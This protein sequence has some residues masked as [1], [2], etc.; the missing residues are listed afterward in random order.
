MEMPVA[1]K[2]PSPPATKRPLAKL[3]DDTAA[4]Y[5][6][7]QAAV[8]VELFTI[9]LY[10]STMYSIQGTHQINS[11]WLSY[12]KGRQ[13]P[14]MG[15]GVRAG[16]GTDAPNQKA[17]NIIFSV[18]IQE[19]LHLQ[20][21]ANLAT[22]IGASPCFTGNALQDD[23]HGWTCYGPTKT[24]IPHI[25]DLQH[26]ENYKH[27]RVALEELNANQCDL[28]LAI[29]QPEDQF[30][31]ELAAFHAAHPQTYFPQ[32]PFENWTPGMTS[33]DLPLF[34]TIGHMYQCYA[35][36]ISIEYE[37][38]ET[39]WDKLYKPG[40]VQQDM[41]NSTVP[42][43]AKAEFPHFATLFAKDDPNTI[44]TFDKAIDMMA[45][46]TDQGEGNESAI[47]RYRRG[48]M[49]K[50]VQPDYREDRA[51]LEADYPSYTNAGGHARSA[52]AAARADY[53][54]YDHY[55]RF[56]QVKDMLAD[57]TTW[58]HWHADPASTWTDAMLTNS[59]YDAAAA[60]DNIPTPAQVATALNNLKQ[61][62][63]TLAM[64]STVA[65]GAVYGITSVLDQYWKDQDL[66]FPYPS[67]VGAGDRFSICWAVLGKSP[68]LSVG[69]P[70]PDQSTLYHACQGLSL[71]GD[72][73]GSNG[74][75]CAA[76]AVYHTCRGSN[77]CHAQGGC[78]FAQLDTGGGSCG[79]AVKA[80]PLPTA[81]NLC[82]GPKPTPVPSFYSAP[83]DNK[84][85]T[86]GGCA[87]PISASQLYPA[88]GTMTLYEF[89]AAPD[90]GAVSIKETLSFSLGDS[91]YDTAWEAYSKVMSARHQDPGAKPAPSDLR[92]ALPPST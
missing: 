39:L 70:L 88:A 55:E 83:S 16:A 65:T 3:A 47:K 27:V 91:V 26:T 31:G 28:F 35:Q 92:I 25:V 6:I 2:D 21:A 64:L 12:Y 69:V 54:A 68:D 42:G 17:F 46:I 60:P 18:F 5:A 77:G 38:G 49:L 86:F 30:Q 80:A 85:K 15:T 8:E 19:M 40:T 79:H 22:A 56:G 50:A 34:G 58:A 45:A 11:K 63:D 14:G 4:L 84:C 76:L 52:D 57:V 74:N 73:Q 20:I 7:A 67:M 90:H 32:V 37:D 51:A 23:Q 1:G 44:A 82:G 62:T 36:Y 71:D 75:A 33:A 9:P 48:A 41:F 13:W 66:G 89:G 43:H 87:V 24:L 53:A 10:M 81:A 78:G 29:E 72:P 61:G 59:E